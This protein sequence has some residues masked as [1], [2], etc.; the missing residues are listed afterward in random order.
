MGFCAYGNLGAPHH[1]HHHHHQISLSPTVVIAKV[2]HKNGEC[3][4]LVCVFSRTKIR[5]WGVLAICNTHL[6]ELNKIPRVSDLFYESFRWIRKTRSFYRV[7]ILALQERGICD[8]WRFS[9][10]ARWKSESDDSKYSWKMLKSGLPEKVKV[11]MES[12]HWK[13]PFLGRLNIDRLGSGL[14]GIILFPNLP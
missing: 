8:W 11:M 4:Y 9:I 14:E 5:V 10:N 1:H 7:K 13:G 6:I 2:F 3:G 12:F